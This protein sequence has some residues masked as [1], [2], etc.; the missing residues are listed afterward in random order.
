MKPNN[1]RSVKRLSQK[2]NGDSQNKSFL[3]TFSSES[4]DS[5]CEPHCDDVPS[6]EGISPV[7]AAKHKSMNKSTSQTI[8]KSKSASVCL[9]DCKYEGHQ[10]KHDMLRCCFCMLWVHPECCGDTKDDLKY[11]GVYSCSE[12]RLIGKRVRNMEKQLSDMHVLNMDLI[13]M[14]QNSQEECSSLRKQLSVLVDEKSQTARIKKNSLDIPGDNFT[15]A[16][17]V[18]PITDKSHCHAS[19][20]TNGNP[21]PNPNT[22]STPVSPLPRPRPRPR[23][24]SSQ[25]NHSSRSDDKPKITLVGDSMVVRGSGPLLAS[26]LT[27][28]NT[29]VNIT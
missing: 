27:E 24:R 19:T 13:K 5:I 18:K 20:Q 4:E 28:H 11:F 1:K 16:L 10:G 22:G 26:E 29:C 15:A 2:Q 25:A 6:F 12:C 14:L 3:P 8:R 7:I 21:I 17:K 23:P 9:E